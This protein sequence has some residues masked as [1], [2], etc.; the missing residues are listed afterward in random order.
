MNAL[1][2][3]P[4]IN[5]AVAVPLV[6]VIAVLVCNRSVMGTFSGCIGIF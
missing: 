1:F 3:S 6:A 2:W 4:V 5:G